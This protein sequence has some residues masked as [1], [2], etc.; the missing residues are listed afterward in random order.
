[1]VEVV[2][3]P[4]V[5]LVPQP[6]PVLE[7]VEPAAAA[8]AATTEFRIDRSRATAAVAAVDPVLPV[9]EPDELPCP[10]LPAVASPEPDSE[11]P[12]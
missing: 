9:V 12:S 6:E 8:F 1:L 11:P 5:V 10:Q 7:V 4:E 3:E 2:V